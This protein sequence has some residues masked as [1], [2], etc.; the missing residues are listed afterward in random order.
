M[1]ADRG[2]PF[3]NILHGLTF[4]VPPEQSL[5]E[6][7]PADTPADIGQVQVSGLAVF[8]QQAGFS[9]KIL[10][11]RRVET[12]HSVEF[13]GMGDDNPSK[14]I[15]VVFPVDEREVILVGTERERVTHRLHRGAFPGGEPDKIVKL[16][17]ST[18]YFGFIIHPGFYLVV[19]LLFFVGRFFPGNAKNY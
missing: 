9:E 13:R 15:V 10:F 4:A 12:S 17:Y 18:R 3:R 2:N 5:P 7:E 16:I 6:T 19:P 11:T 8:L 1:L 14:R